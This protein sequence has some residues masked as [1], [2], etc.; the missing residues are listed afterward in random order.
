[1]PTLRSPPSEAV[2]DFKDRQ[3]DPILGKSGWLLP[4]GLPGKLRRLESEVLDRVRDEPSSDDASHISI[5]GWL[6]PRHQ[7]LTA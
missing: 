5:I 6:G 3:A 7:G 2:R 1:M 4:V